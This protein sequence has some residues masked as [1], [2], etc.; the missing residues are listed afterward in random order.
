MRDPFVYKDTNI[1]VN[2]L[3][4]KDQE[5]LDQYESV[6]FQLAFTRLM[7]EGFIITSVN[8]VFE[9][10]KVLFSEVYDW[11]GTARTI[12]IQKYEKV[13]NGLSVNYCDKS[14]IIKSLNTLDENFRN[15][16]I[17]ANFINDLTKF[18]AKIWQI[19]PFREGNTRT[20]TV[21]LYFLLKMYK[22]ELNTELIEKSSKYFRNALVLA[23]IGEYSEYDHLEIILQEAIYGK[24][25]EMNKN[26]MN[27]NKYEKIKDLDLS[28]Y[29]YNYHTKK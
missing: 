15:L 1:L 13:L 3:G 7:N 20:I 23:S 14:S 25:I 11:A 17:K 6:I 5:S 19:H 16:N 21:F 8:D 12:N 27:E 2:K 22:L 24:Q 9:L 26:D 10:H 18:I 29:K 4:L 28:K